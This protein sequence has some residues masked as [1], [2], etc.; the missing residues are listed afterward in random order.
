[1]EDLRDCEG[2]D[3]ESKA[4]EGDRGLLD[5]EDVVIPRSQHGQAHAPLAL[6][7]MNLSVVYIQMIRLLSG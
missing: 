3:R 6:P 5:F 4:S 1:M 2:F 7:L